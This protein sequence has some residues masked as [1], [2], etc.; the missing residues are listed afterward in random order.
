MA[1][2]NIPLPERFAINVIPEPMSGCHLWI[3]AIHGQGYG[4]IRMG[5]KTHRAHRI[6]WILRHGH[7][8]EGK[9][10]LHGCDNPP[11]VNINH[12]HLGDAFDN[13]REAVARGLNHQRR[14]THCP[15][16]HPYAGANL[17]VQETPHQRRICRT[18]ERMANGRGEFNQRRSASPGMHV[19]AR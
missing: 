5:G 12:L 16:G 8:P 4:L 19:E 15:K 17:R 2:R 9:M 6:A 13:Q 1:D 10:V 18:C 11:C 7:I 3:G 14:K